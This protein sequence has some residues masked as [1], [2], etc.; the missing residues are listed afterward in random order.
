MNQTP[1]QR[2]AEIYKESDLQGIADLITDLEAVK[3]LCNEHLEKLNIA[4]KQVEQL[5]RDRERLDWLESRIDWR[6]RQNIFNGPETGESLRE[7]ID[8]ASKL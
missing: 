1:E 5:K 7:R 6:D 3:R 4:E 8:T 2:A